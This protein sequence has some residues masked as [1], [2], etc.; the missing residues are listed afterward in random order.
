MNY[1]GKKKICHIYYNTAGNSGLYLNP[2]VTALAE[3]YYQTLFVN[4]YYPLNIEGFNRIFF[5][6]TEKNEHNHHKKIMKNATIRKIV[7]FIELK[8]G[9]RKMLKEMAD[10]Q[11][12]VINYSLTNMPDALDTIRRLKRILPKAKIIVTCH[13]VV[14]FSATNGIDY[15]TIYD[16]AD[17]LLVHT[18]NAINILKTVYHVPDNKIIYHSFPSI[19]LRLLNTSVR[20]ENT[21]NCPTF[22]FIGVMRKEKG[23]QNLIDAWLNLGE[24]FPAKLMIAGFKP[25]DV[26]INFDRIQ[27]FRNVTTIIKSLSDEEYYNCVE[28]ADY[29]VFPYSKVGNSGV[30]STITSLGKVP[31]TTNLPTFQ[32][33]KYCIDGLSC[34]PDNIE[35]LEELLRDIVQKHSLNYARYCS[36]IEKV[37]YE[38]R[39]A[40]REE[41]LEAYG[42]IV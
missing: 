3:N 37:L 6:L 41:I 36:T 12:D 14:P 19:D 29:V 24:D 42:R 1:Q 13:D 23:V 26:E 10:T 33:S 4:F 34:V 27:S 15:Q 28:A 20:K 21:K 7:R 22:L 18:L 11:Y 39:Q 2:I 38:E 40:F 35:A 25:D 5:R 17:V 9:N 31:V 30:L 8:I 16:E 32:E